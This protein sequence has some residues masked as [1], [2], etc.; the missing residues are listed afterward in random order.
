[1]FQVMVVQFNYMAWHNFGSISRKILP[2]SLNI[3]GFSW[4]WRIL[5]L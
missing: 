3:R 5:V 1:M 4:I 2:L